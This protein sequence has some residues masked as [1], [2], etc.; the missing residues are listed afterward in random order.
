MFAGSVQESPVIEPML[1]ECWARVAD[2]GS[3]LGGHQSISRRGEAAIFVA[4]KL[5]I[6][7]LLGGALKISNLITCFHRLII[8]VNYL[9][10]A[11]SARNYL[12]KKY[13][14]FPLGD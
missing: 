6:L 1:W 5:F 12:F 7:N 11:E 9:F 3:A 2:G 14:S 10:H 13:Y 8:E 4:D